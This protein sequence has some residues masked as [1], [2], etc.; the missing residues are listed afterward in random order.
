M[1]INLI[2]YTINLKC[3]LLIVLECQFSYYKKRVDFNLAFVI[4]SRKQNSKENGFTKK[5]SYVQQSLEFF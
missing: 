5:M 1:V 2:L 4:L 3:I